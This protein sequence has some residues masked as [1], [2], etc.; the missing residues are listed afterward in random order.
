MGIISLRQVNEILIARIEMWLA[1]VSI[2]VICDT[3]EQVRY[4]S[5]Y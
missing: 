4:I 5:I 2:A 3:K 1:L